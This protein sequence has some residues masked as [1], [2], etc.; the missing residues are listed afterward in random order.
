MAH[1]LQESQWFFDENVSDVKFPRSYNPSR[2][3]NSFVQD[4]RRSS[5]VGLLKWFVNCTE[6][7]GSRVNDE[8]EEEDEGAEEKAI[9]STGLP[10]SL[11]RIEFAIR[12]CED[13]ALE[14][15]NED[16][17]TEEA[18]ELSEEEWNSFL[19]EATKVIQTS[20]VT[21]DEISETFR[22][23]AGA[24]EVSACSDNEATCFLPE[25]PPHH[26]VIYYPDHD[27]AT[28]LRFY[29]SNKCSRFI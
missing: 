5:A 17:D 28:S 2:E 24:L 9:Q 7:L 15:E 29:Y 3:L 22:A 23:E 25:F 12:V 10:I 1:V 8:G 20:A 18:W 6:E 26:A 21:A 27:A 19:E 13:Q 16:I 11:S 4:F 14:Y